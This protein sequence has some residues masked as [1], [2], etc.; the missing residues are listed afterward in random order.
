[1]KCVHLQGFRSLLQLV[2][3][4][5]PVPTGTEVLLK[6]LGAGV[7]HSDAH[8]WEGQYDLGG[9][10]TMS[11]AERIKF[12]LV[13]G[14]E[15]SGEVVGL[16]PQAQG[17]S[18]GSRYAVCSWIGCGDCRFCKIGDEHLCVAPRFLGVN[19]DGGYAD[20][21]LVPDGR[22][23]IDI[24]DLDPVAAAPLVC[25]GLTTYSALKKAGPVLQQDRIVVIGAGGLGLMALNLLRILGVP[26]AVVVEPNAE[27]RQAALEAGALAAIDP[28][29]TDAAQQVRNALGNPVSFVL[30]LVGSAESASLGYELLD[31][32]GKMVVVGLFGG[33]MEL[34]VP[35]LPMRAVTLQ[36][37][38][39]GSPAE[40]RELIELVRKSGG[41]AVRV[42]RRPL[43]EA[44][45]ALQD[46][47][48][49]RVV[50]RVVLVP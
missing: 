48:A 21:I 8:I 40:L 4:P 46:L 44:D 38:Y 47:R 15:T 32:V 45:Q 23:L 50:G 19:R 28:G 14:H 9:G 39:I 33:A 29:A 3:K 5:T 11:M 25:S 42:D 36:G 12:P 49:G 26:G 35:L 2:E 31:R 6:V 16:G 41:L 1:M 17:V 37:S 27:K 34:S 43:A 7:C 24:G 13:M 20:H 10:R 22:Y 18:L 30:D